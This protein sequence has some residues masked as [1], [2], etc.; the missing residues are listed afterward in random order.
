MNFIDN[1]KIATKIVVV[2]ALLSC[3]TIMVVA[4][5]AISLLNVDGAY[6]IIANREF[7]TRVAVARTN[8]EITAIGYAA[9]RTI[10]YDGDSAEAKAGAAATETAYGNAGQYLAHAVELDSSNKALYEGFKTRIEAIHAIAQSVV[11]HG[12][13]N[14]D[15][16]ATAQMVKG[17]ALIQ[18]LSADISNENNKEIE[19]TIAQA[20][21]A[22]ASAQAT[23]IITVG[24]GI[25]GLVTCLGIGLWLAM[26]KIAQ[27]LTRLGERMNMLAQGKLDTE[28]EGTE[29]KDEIGQMARTV[30]VF[31][32]GGLEKVGL[33]KAAA[34]QR[35]QAEQ[36]R[37]E[38]EEE[39]RINAET[40]AVA[41]KEQASAV[42]ALGDG[43]GKMSEGDLT[44]HLN[45][46]FT[47]A[48]QQ[49]KD[50]FNN[51]IGRLKETI[52]SIVSSTRDVTSASAEISTSTTDLSQ[53]TEEQA[54]S[55]EQTSASMEEISATVKKN[56]E[57]AQHANE[58]AGKARDVA[59]RGGKVVAKAVEA[60]A[61]IESSAGKISDI[62][63][64]IDEIARQTN[65]LALNAAVEAARAGDA[66]RGFAVVASEVRT[67]AQRSS[68]A[69]KDIK[70]LITNSNGQV[71]EGVKL[72]NQAGAALVEIV[73]SIK[74]VAGV[75]SEI[76]SA[77]IEQATGIEQVNKAL[78]QMDEVTQQNSALVE[79]NAATAKTLETQAQAMGER[80][81]FFRVGQ[82][83]THAAPSGR[84]APAPRPQVAA[85]RPAAAPSP[86]RTV[87][88]TNRGPVGRMQTSLAT[89]IKDDPDWKE[90]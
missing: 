22:S 73:A 13:K 43:L 76:A 18:A 9:Y 37:L 46:G 10:A 82:A 55:L 89:A 33:E 4:L 36:Q 27:P 29:R 44:V 68:Q 63:G 32:E 31:R 70:G 67:L 81:S 48:Y 34:E 23:I 86:K 90:F 6:S 62:I 78:N 19:K 24:I 11:A 52:E 14:E 42:K 3:V 12:L 2:I 45:E 71:Q 7:P 59:D 15:K 47:D 79:E 40:Q 75:V 65:L 26:A 35:Q 38:A 72:V 87:A 88:G 30:L 8:R 84:S 60:M 20:A 1:W 69:A 85:R 56:S 49:I 53:R 41:A 64:V 74:E 61:E 16:E 28:I 51:T 77:S 17:D 80:I 5:G 66:G 54:A 50:D 21:A 83:E 25:A 57:N 39:R 58:S